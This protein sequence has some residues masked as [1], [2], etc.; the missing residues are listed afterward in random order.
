MA[1]TNPQLVTLKAAI[2][3]DSALNAQ[4]MN[5]DGAFAIATV[6]NLN[7]S[8]D[9]WVHKKSVDTMDVG[10][11]INYVAYEAMTSANITKIEGF[12][13]LNPSTFVPERSDIRA[14][15]NNVFSGALGGQGQAT[16]DALD[17]LFRRLAT[18]FERLYATGTG[19]VASPGALVLVG[20]LSYQDVEAARALP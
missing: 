9:F 4:P 1:L 15:F 6:L 3:A 11:T 13:R 12:I 2:V 10:K 14:F 5:S 20:P 7:A 8:P 17:L 19:S 16:R 18:R